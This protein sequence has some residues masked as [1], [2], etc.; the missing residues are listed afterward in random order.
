MW[1]VDISCSALSKT[2]E[3][4]EKFVFPQG[5]VESR[6]ISFQQLMN[7]HECEGIANQ[8]HSKNGV[9]TDPVF[10]RFKK[11]LVFVCPVKR[12]RILD[13]I[14]K[15]FTIYMKVFDV[16]AIEAEA[17]EKFYD[18]PFTLRRFEILQVFNSFCDELDSYWR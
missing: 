3:L 7:L 14:V 11:F 9:F 4:K 6:Y 8:R 1:R 17:P 18:I 2:G 15:R 10:D 5:T 16:I 12:C 13:E